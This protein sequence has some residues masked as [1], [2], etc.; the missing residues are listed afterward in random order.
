MS[1]VA[2]VR[3][4]SDGLV[5]TPI[6]T[7]GQVIPF[8]V[9]EGLATSEGLLDSNKLQTFGCVMDNG[10]V[11]VGI[12]GEFSMKNRDEVE[13]VFMI[14]GANP[15]DV[16]KIPMGRIHVLNCKLQLPR[17]YDVKDR[18]SKNLV[19][20]SVTKVMQGYWDAQ[21]PVQTLEEVA[22]GRRRARLV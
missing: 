2:S 18:P 17:G 11:R 5:V 4:I 1:G 19:R 12:T 3:Y 20:F 9:C 15:E 14:F 10:D 7:L 16:V 22:R 8:P 21:V 6:Y 13:N